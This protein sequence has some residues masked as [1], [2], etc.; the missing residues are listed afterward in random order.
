MITKERVGIIDYQLRTADDVVFAS[1]VS[2]PFIQ[3]MGNILPGMEKALMNKEIGDNI[4]AD[5]APEDAFG[6]HH[7]FTPVVFQKSDLGS[8]FEKLSVGMA[9]PFS[10]ENGKDIVLYVSAL[11]GSDATFTINHPLAGQTLR[12][13]ASVKGVR[14]ATEKEL[15]SGF[16]HGL[17]GKDVPK[18]S[19]AC[20]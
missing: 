3:G 15:E 8:T 18:S 16:P 6:P 12:F 4:F 10:D 7:D 5:I 14:D 19:C 17:D 9:I 20:C 13:N 11:T 1:Y 2:S